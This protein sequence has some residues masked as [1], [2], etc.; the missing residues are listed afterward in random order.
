MQFAVTHDQ[1]I[2]NTPLPASAAEQQCSSASF[3]I[4]HGDHGNDTHL[5]YLN[6]RIP[7]YTHDF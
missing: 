2:R 6:L 3:G 5:V 7:F 1:V 4:L